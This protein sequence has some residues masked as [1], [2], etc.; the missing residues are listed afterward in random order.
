M[1]ERSQDSNGRKIAPRLI[2][3][4]GSPGRS[5]FFWPED[6]KTKSEWIPARFLRGE[7]E[8][9]PEMGELEVM[10][11]F[12]R[13]SHLNYSIEGQFYPLGSCTMKY[14]PKLNE[15]VARLPG[16][17]LLHPLLPG[18]RST[19]QNVLRTVTAGK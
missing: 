12:T 8:G 17:S 6:T 4:T 1:S 15:V 14:N 19:C 5:G 2:F 18:D 11:H 16:L 3:E 7:I 13:L 9:F 10:R